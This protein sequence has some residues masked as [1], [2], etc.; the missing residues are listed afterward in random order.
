[1]KL[2]FFFAELVSTFFFVGKIKFAPGTFGSIASLIAIYPFLQ[3]L[4][5]YEQQYILF[6][7]LFI[8]TFACDYYMKITKKNDPKEVVIDEALGLWLCLFINQYM[9]PHVR[10]EIIAI[11]SLILF[12][13]FDILKPFPINLIDKNMKNALGVMLDD[14]FAGI[15]GSLVFFVI[16]TMF[17]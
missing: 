7:T 8:G 16:A 13:F 14:V 1:M 4:S 3:N 11:S 5:L 17:L 10:L 15:A 6:A 2:K 9:A 12:R